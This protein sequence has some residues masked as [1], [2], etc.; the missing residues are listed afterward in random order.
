[1]A[2][3]EVQKKYNYTIDPH[4]AIGYLAFRLHQR[5]NPSH[6]GI[7]LE[8][9]HPAKFLE[10]MED[11]LQQKIKLPDKLAELKQKE[12]QATP[13]KADYPTLKEWL[14]ANFKK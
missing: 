9:A 6:C 10:S 7:I 11:I 14:F 5:T 4:G 1:M 2:I 3:R 12:K 8:T 13:M